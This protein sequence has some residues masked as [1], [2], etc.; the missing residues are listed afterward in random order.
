MK[1]NWIELELNSKY[2]VQG[3]FFN[4]SVKKGFKKDFLEKYTIYKVLK[5][6]EDSFY[7]IKN[8]YDIKES[9]L[10]GYFYIYK[11]DDIL[12]ETI[13]F[14]TGIGEAKD[15]IFQYRE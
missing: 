2:S 11:E 7:L 1:A 10:I 3:F 5:K 4:S 15:V 13:F 9:V 6:E 12:S 14:I 8:E